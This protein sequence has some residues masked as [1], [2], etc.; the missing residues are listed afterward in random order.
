MSAL[1]EPI[2]H[3]CDGSELS[4]S[5]VCLCGHLRP[6]M[7]QKTRVANDRSQEAQQAL[8]VVAPAMK[9]STKQVLEDR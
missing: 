4:Q 6:F 7:P 8:L 3:D 9:K 5:R 1:H 2:L